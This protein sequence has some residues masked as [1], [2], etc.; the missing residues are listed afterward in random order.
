MKIIKDSWAKLNEEEK[1]EYV[2]M[3]EKAAKKAKGKGNATVSDDEDK[4]KDAVKPK[5]VKSAYNIFCK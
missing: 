3:A 2:E 1:E 5:K 4:F